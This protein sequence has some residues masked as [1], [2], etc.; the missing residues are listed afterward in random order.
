MKKNKLLYVM[1]FMVFC[2]VC[3]T[4]YTL[5]TYGQTY[6]HSDTEAS[7]RY[8]NS[9]VSSGQLFPDT[10]NY[11]NSELYTSYLIFNLSYIMYTLVNNVIIAR[12]IAS[13]IVLAITVISVIWFSKV[14]LKN[15][16]WVISIPLFFVFIRSNNSREMILWETEYIN[17]IIAFTLVFGITYMILFRSKKLY[18]VIL[19]CIFLVM[20]TASGTRY[21]AEY[22][23]PY[24]AATVL[25]LFIEKRL[26]GKENMIVNIKNIMLAIIIPALIGY[27]FYAYICSNHLMDSGTYYNEIEIVRSI[28]EIVNNIR[29]TGKN[30]INIFGYNKD[31]GALNNVVAI[32]VAVAI[33]F[34]GPVLECLNFKKF[35]HEKKTLILFGVIHNILLLG[36][37]IVAT[38]L[39]ERYLLS[40]V[41]IAILF[42]ADYIYSLCFD[43][44]KKVKY[45]F[46]PLFMALTVLLSINLAS[47]SNVNGGWKEVLASQKNVGD[48]LAKKGIT[49]GYAS[50]W[51]A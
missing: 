26:L 29:F 49:K 36:V 4:A 14:F 43:D 12:V 7:L 31:A 37:I 17:I 16:S 47:I 10:W 51:N 13:V 2:V 23:L 42:S 39:I 9:M 18:L 3:I 25:I 19:N 33:F 15:E 6:L 21:L 40:S 30:L 5:V 46:I 41:F 48:I 20:L 27:G 28:G 1:A 24:F 34:I 11:N 38:K 45:I 8:Y 35:S 22:I 50:Y 44:N 32:I